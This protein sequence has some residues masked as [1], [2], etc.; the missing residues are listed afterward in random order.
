MDVSRFRK[1]GELFD[2]LVELSPD[3]RAVRLQERC[4]DPNLRAEIEAMLRAD[5]EGDSFEMRVQLARV[6]MAAADGTSTQ[7]DD[8][9]NIRFGVW[10]VRRE[11]GRG[12]MG[13]VYLV[14]RETEGLA[15]FGA[16]KLIRRGMN[17]DPI[18]ARFLCERQVLARLNHPGIARLLDGGMSEDGQPY[19]V[20]DYVDGSSLR[21]YADT[22]G[23]AETLRLFVD[24]CA[25]V[26]YAHGRLVVHRD[27]KPS[28]VLV[29]RDGQAKLL[30]FGIAKLLG[31]GPASEDATS[32][33]ANPLTPRYAAPEQ[34]RGDPVGIVTD[35]FGLGLLLFEILTGRLPSGLRALADAPDYVRLPKASDSCSDRAR[36]TRLRGD[37]D[38]IIARAVEA[39]PARRYPSADAMA[40]DVQRYLGNRPILARP[41]SIAYVI[42]KFWQRHRLAVATSGLLLLGS[43]AGFGLALWQAGNARSQAERAEAVTAFLVDIFE[44]NRA[45]TL[46]TAKARETTVVQLLSMAN[47]RILE[48][49]SLPPLA[50]AHLLG[51]LA[52]QS[53]GLDMDEVA[54]RLYVAQIEQLVAAS[55]SMDELATPQSALAQAALNLGDYAAAIKLARAQL[56]SVGAPLSHER[57]LAQASLRVTLATSL[58]QTGAP[59]A[60]SDIANEALKLLGPMDANNTIRIDAL[61][62][63]GIAQRSLGNTD[64]AL[65]YFQ[66]ALVALGDAKPPRPLEV[67]RIS[68]NMARVYAR[69]GRAALAEAAAQRAVIEARRVYAAHDRDLAYYR[70]DLATFI[71]LQGR[72]DEA[73]AHFDEAIADLR[74]HAAGS[75]SVYLGTA[76]YYRAGALLGEGRLD[77]A[78]ADIKEA[79]TIWQA[80][81]PNATMRLL[82][83]RMAA[84]VALEQGEYQRARDLLLDTVDGST[85]SRSEAVPQ[86]LCTECLQELVA[87]EIRAGHLS[88]AR[89][90]L[91]LLHARRN[92]ISTHGSPQVAGPEE[93][94]AAWLLAMR[95]PSAALIVLA[96]LRAAEAALPAERRS[97]LA[98]VRLLLL[99]GRALFDAG[100]VNEALGA[101]REY[102]ARYAAM[103]GASPLRLP[104][105]AAL[106]R[107]E[108][109]AGTTDHALDAM[110][111]AQEI[112]SAHTRLAPH[113][114]DPVDDAAKAF[115]RRK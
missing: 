59:E 104:G 74:L 102:D 19:F 85:S 18:V 52:Q 11:L 84:A 53:A 77:L 23:I 106:A 96:P 63:L 56:V 100:R 47:Q 13:I 30:D 88:E 75:N 81:Q 51:V 55:A 17:S 37:L 80:G 78:D 58:N 12:G 48:E 1:I 111:M 34:L 66:N 112:V 2:E 108:L 67:A 6:Q 68:S 83:K 91:D 99:W 95:D 115:E 14:E 97:E 79:A 89:T 39:D 65:D 73:R 27:I 3:E 94:E 82:L 76:L 36:A 109:V 20:M 61:D 7:W 98:A 64:A 8:L 90:L 32:T 15:Q 38:T 31:E 50:K 41:T 26:A 57:R 54:Q 114:R 4:V 24:V 9:S 22:H 113:L 71:A 49:Q 107:A 46:D 16:L 10:G 93:L 25:A 92:E 101:L 87:V 42:L 21:E 105:I 28:N 62:Q 33:S 5:A 35:V 86:N 29:T 60:V 70:M 72:F 45:G 44:R 110:R 40:Q 69:D 103:V 43:I